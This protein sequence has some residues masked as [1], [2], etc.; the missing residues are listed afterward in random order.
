MGSHRLKGRYRIL[1][2]VDSYLILPRRTGANAMVSRVLPILMS[3]IIA[4]SVGIVLQ[5]DR[6]ERQH[7]RSDRLP[8]SPGPILTGLE[9][10]WYECGTRRVRIHAARGR[11]ERQRIGFLQTALVPVLELEDVTVERLPHDGASGEMMTLPLARVNWLAKALVSDSGRVLLR[12]QETPQ[13]Q[14]PHGSMPD[15]FC[16]G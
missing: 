1:P 3:V 12:M 9:F 15:A 16:Q 4:S 6:S 14:V 13:G 11:V 10:S 7:E 2:S 8:A 5:A